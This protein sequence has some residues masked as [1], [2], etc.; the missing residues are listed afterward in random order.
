MPAH[1]NAEAYLDAYIAA[2]GIGDQKK[3]PLSRSMDKHR[4]LTVSPMHRNDVLRM[5]KRRSHVAALPASTAAILSGLPASPPFWRTGG[6]IENAQ[7]HSRPRIA[8]HNQALRPH[9]R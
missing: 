3:G 2:A 8:A 4:K 5:I 7:A 6:T 1:H 9:Q